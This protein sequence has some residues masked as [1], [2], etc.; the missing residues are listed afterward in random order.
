MP[1]IVDDPNKGESVTPFMYFYKTI[2]QSDVS[3]DRL[4]LRIVVIGYL[5]K[6][7]MIGVKWYPTAPMRTIKYFLED[8]SR[9]KVRLHQLHFIGSFIQVNVKHR[10]FLKF[11]IRNG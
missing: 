5:Q 6:K 7:E 4:K 3:L 8:D 10:V 9:H 2:I 1:F 11:E